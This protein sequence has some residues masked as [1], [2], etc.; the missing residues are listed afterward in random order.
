M[1][2]TVIFTAFCACYNIMSKENLQITRVM[3]TQCTNRVLAIV[4]LHKKAGLVDLLGSN[5]VYSGW[6]FSLQ[7]EQYTVI[8]DRHSLPFIFEET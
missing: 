7:L 3:L 4:I 6:E 5:L 8:T 2:S 1:R